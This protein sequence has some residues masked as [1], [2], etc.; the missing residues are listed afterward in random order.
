MSRLG[1]LAADRLRQTAE[2][3][4]MTEPQAELLEAWRSVANAKLVEFRRQCWRLSGL[5]RAGTVVKADAIDQ[6]WTIAIAHALVR[7]CGEDRIECIIAEAFCD[8][9]DDE[10][11]QLELCAEAAE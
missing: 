5:V 6:L 2:S 9:P 10:P 11:Y 7:A 3:R 4:V 1:P 8:L